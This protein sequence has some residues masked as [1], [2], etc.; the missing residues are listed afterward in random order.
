MILIRDL[1]V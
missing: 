1:H